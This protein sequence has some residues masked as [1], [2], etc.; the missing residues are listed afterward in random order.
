[1]ICFSDDIIVTCTLCYLV[2]LI[3]SFALLYRY[4]EIKMNIK[5]LQY[6]EVTL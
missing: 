6:N 4:V 3:F 5:Q 2:K 1:M